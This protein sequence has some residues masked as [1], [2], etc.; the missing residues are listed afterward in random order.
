MSI[1]YSRSLMCIINS[2]NR[3]ANK[4]SITLYTLILISHRE[5]W[6]GC[7]NCQL[8][9]VSRSLLIT[10]SARARAHHTMTLRPVAVWLAALEARGTARNPSVTV[11]L[12][13]SLSLRAY[14]SGHF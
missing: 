5:A 10:R 9:G 12:K 8:L 4:C 3:M 1:L 7:R 13:I 14:L 11:C 2:M 6:N